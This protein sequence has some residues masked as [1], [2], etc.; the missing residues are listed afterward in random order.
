VAGT[1][2]SSQSVTISTST[3]GASIY[4]TTNGTTPTTN[5]NLYSSPVT[6][7][8]TETLQAIGVKTGLASSAVA[9]AQYTINLPAAATPVPNPSPGTYAGTQTLSFTDSTSGS[10]MYCTTNGNAPTIASTPYTAP[11]TVSLTQTIQCIAA[12]PGFTTSAIG[13]GTYYIGALIP[14]TL[15]GSQVQVVGSSVKIV[16][17]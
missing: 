8:S 1:Y 14:P 13:G 3:S 5:S 4:Y 9:S 15:Q 12:A 7:A 6:V 16:S 10:T 2:T 17:Q 11:F